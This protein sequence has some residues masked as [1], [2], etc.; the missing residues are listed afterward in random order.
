MFDYSW[1]DDFAAARNFSLEQ[2]RGRWLLVID[3]DEIIAA[4]DL[5]KL[6]D[7]IGQTSVATL[8]LAYQLVTRN[9]TNRNDLVGS[10]GN[11]GS[12]PDAE[13]GCAWLPSAKVRLWQNHPQIRFSYPVHELVEPALEKLGV[14]YRKSDLVVHHYGKLD[15]GKDQEKGRKYLEIGLRKLEDFADSP[16]SV[17]ELAVQAGMLRE[18]SAAIK[19][20]R[21]FLDTDQDNAEAWLNLGTALFNESRLKEALAAVIQAGKLQPLMKEPY[22][23]RSLYDLHLGQPRPAAHRLQQLLLQVP[24]YQPARFLLAAAICLRDGVKA[25]RKTFSG[26][27]D[28]QINREMIAIA[29]R[30]LAASLE[31]CRRH[32]DARKIKEA[33]SA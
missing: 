16:E 25:G 31:R 3:P 14:E 29:G 13:K 26:L 1:H 19:L 2:A 10:R 33:T 11:D 32:Q 20:W 24:D 15:I 28:Q 22:F 8:P 17:R 6:E 5:G 18:H 9:Y 27:L 7:I 4:A 21:R 12:Y 23:N 30:E